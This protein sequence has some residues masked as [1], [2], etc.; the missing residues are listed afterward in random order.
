[1][2]EVKSLKVIFYNG[3]DRVVLADKFFGTRA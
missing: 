3:T 1:M 2:K